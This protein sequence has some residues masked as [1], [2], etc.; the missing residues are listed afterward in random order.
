MHSGEDWI[1]LLDD[2]L[3]Q[4][5][6]V[7]SDSFCISALQKGDPVCVTLS[8]CISSGTFHRNN[9]T[10]DDRGTIWR[11]RSTQSP[12]LQLLVPKPGRKELFQL[13]HASLFGGHLGHT[14]TLARLSHRFYWSGMSDDVKEWLDQ[15]VVCVKRKSP[16][17]RHHPL[18]NILTGHRWDRIAMDILDVCDPTP[19]GYR[20]ILVIADYFWRKLSLSRTNAPTRW[21]ISWLRTLF[22]DLGCHWL[23]IATRGGSSRMDLWNRCAPFWDAQR[24]KRHLITRSRMAWLNA[25]T[26]LVLWCYP[27]LSTTG[28]IIGTN[29]S[30]ML[31][32]LTEQAST[33]RL[34]TPHIVSWWEMSVLYHRTFL[35]LNFALT[36][37]RTL[38]H[39]CSLRGSGTPWR[40]PMAMSESHSAERRPAGKDYMILK[41]WTGN[42]QVDRGCYDIIHRR[43]NINLVSHGWIVGVTI[44]STG[45]ST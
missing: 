25:L 2:D 3:S 14:R 19:D 28:G 26:E 36:E 35:R 17:G 22:W 39:I 24:L 16:N 23:S 45:G 33:S 1:V 38:H 12:M 5:S 18:R 32:M 31:C 29:Y 20:Y 43:L 15:C 37:N 6:T 34:V 9:L 30:H 44:L 10:L 40:L 8:S 42:F 7:A 4:P 11:K 41:Q 27:C 13:Y 21:G